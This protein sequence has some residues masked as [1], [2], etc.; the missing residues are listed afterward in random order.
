MKVYRGYT[1]QEQAG[2]EAAILVYEEDRPAEELRQM[3]VHS[4]SG[5]AWGYGGT[6]AA[7]QPI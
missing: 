1:D 3:I 5:M 7:A 6:A 4:P 2:P